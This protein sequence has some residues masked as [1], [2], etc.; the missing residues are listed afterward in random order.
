MFNFTDRELEFAITSLGMSV[1]SFAEYMNVEVQKVYKLMKEKGIKAD[2]KKCLFDKGTIYNIE[3]LAEHFDMPLEL[4]EEGYRQFNTRYKLITFEEAVKQVVKENKNPTQ[5]AEELGC[6]RQNIHKILTKYG[7]YDMLPKADDG[8]RSVSLLKLN[9]KGK[10]IEQL[11]LDGKSVDYISE[12]LGVNRV[13]VYDYLKEN[14]LYEN[15]NNVDIDIDEFID[16]YLQGFNCVEIAKKMDV[17][18]STLYNR[19]KAEGIKEY[20]FYKNMKVVDLD[21]DSIYDMYVNQ[22][23]TVE[24]IAEEV[25]LSKDTVYAYMVREGIFKRIR[26]FNYME[27]II[28]KDLGYSDEDI[29]KEFKIN[30]ETYDIAK[31]KNRHKIEL[32]NKIMELK[33]SGVSAQDISVELDMPYNN[34]LYY[35]RKFNTKMDKYV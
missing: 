14:F 19:I 32:I 5:L 35:I 31:I 9:Q 7:I 21:R 3:E 23:M 29:A 4:V 18:V 25:G 24:S 26:N 2:R 28:L 30:K 33:N 12:Q 13:Y 15:R 1:S 10:E 27:Y 17:N 6:S 8:R 22:N 20:E 16:L 11:Y 34:V